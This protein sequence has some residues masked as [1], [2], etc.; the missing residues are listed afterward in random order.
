M[1][2]KVI[3]MFKGIL[4]SNKR[5]KFFHWTNDQNNRKSIK[6]TRSWD[7]ELTSK[8]S[9]ERQALSLNLNNSKNSRK[10][11]IEF[12]KYGSFLFK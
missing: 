12:T 4:N 1:N 11:E 9:I 8:H 10:L 3:K 5:K 2:I 7:W 6:A